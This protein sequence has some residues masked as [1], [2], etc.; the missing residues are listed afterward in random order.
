MLIRLVPF[1]YLRDI[2]R[3][4]Q[5]RGLV[6]QNGSA[7]ESAESEVSF[8]GVLTVGGCWVLLLSSRQLERK[9]NLCL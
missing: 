8:Y 3:S 1:R 7:N 5:P 4:L 9:G 6:V 2:S